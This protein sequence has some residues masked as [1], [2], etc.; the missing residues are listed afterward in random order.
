MYGSCLFNLMKPSCFRM[1]TLHVLLTTFCVYSCKILIFLRT[2]GNLLFGQSSP[3]LKTLTK[4]NSFQVV[5]KRNSKEKSQGMQP[6]GL[7]LGLLQIL[8]FF[9]MCVF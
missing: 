9:F 2:I 6:Y 4:L 1:R 7:F 3:R 5:I 8:F